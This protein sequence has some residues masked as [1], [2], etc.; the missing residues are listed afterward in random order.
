[1]MTAPNSPRVRATVNT[2]PYVSP[3]RMDGR[4]IRQNV[5]HHCEPNVAAAS[6]WS[7][8]NSCSTGSTSRITNGTVTKMLASTMPGNPKMIFKPKSFSTNPK[9]PAVPHNRI[10][11]TPT[12]TGDTANGKS[13]IACNTLLPRNLLRAR[14]SAVGTP[15]RTLSGTTIAT[16]SNDS[17]SA[18]TAAGVVIDSKNAPTPGVNVRHKINPTGTINSRKR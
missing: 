5:C 18:D 6:S 11:A 14:T 12:T 15:N 16:T 13:M 8:P 10:S 2:T 17:C 1:M 3:Q 7:V 9:I 4:V